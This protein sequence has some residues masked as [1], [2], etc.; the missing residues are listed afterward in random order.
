MS[1][2]EVV[3]SD[4][5]VENVDVRGTLRAPG[6]VVELSDEDASELVASGVLKPVEGGNPPAPTAE[7]GADTPAVDGEP[8]TVAPENAGEAVVETAGA[9]T[10]GAQPTGEAVAT[11]ETPTAEATDE[12]PKA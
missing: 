8:T 10:E 12:T 5:T 1:Q 6:E 4:P 3:G 2:F 11:P 9:E 7:A